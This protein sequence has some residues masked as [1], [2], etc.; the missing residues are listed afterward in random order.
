MMMNDIACINVAKLKKKKLFFSD[1][2]K[3]GRNI[4]DLIG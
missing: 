4:G 2:K 3:E 1:V